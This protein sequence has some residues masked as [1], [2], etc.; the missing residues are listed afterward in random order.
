MKCGGYISTTIQSYNTQYKV[1][2][3]RNEIGEHSFVKYDVRKLHNLLYY[4]DCD[5]A[6]RSAKVDGPW[7]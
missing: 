5:R 2:P 4:E 1:R 3:R 7:A 6:G